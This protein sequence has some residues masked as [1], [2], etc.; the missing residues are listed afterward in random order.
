MSSDFLRIEDNNPEASLRLVLTGRVTVEQARELHEAATGLSRR[1][2]DVAVCCENVEYLHPA[3]IQV[4]LSLGR[5]MEVHGHFC[6]LVN[7]PPSVRADFGL[8]GLGHV[9]PE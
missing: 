5:E 7:V 4:L 6:D 9:L 8:I 1:N 3:A 2:R